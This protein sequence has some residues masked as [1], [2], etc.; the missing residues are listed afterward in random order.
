[1]RFTTPVEFWDVEKVPYVLETGRKAVAAKKEEILSAI[2]NFDS[3]N[4]S[5]SD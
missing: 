1:V 5:A 3:F 2:H 4:R